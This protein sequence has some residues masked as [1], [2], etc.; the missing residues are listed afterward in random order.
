MSLAR[1]APTLAAGLQELATPAPLFTLPNAS[2]INVTAQ[3]AGGVGEEPSIAP[4]AFKYSLVFFDSSCRLSLAGGS[5]EKG[6]LPVM[7]KI[8]RALLSVSDKTGLV[9]SRPNAGGG[10]VELISTGGT[11]KALREAGLTVRTSASTPASRKC[12][13]AG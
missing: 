6:R 8:R 5:E 10:G 4:Q 2:P 3:D 12:S 1:L 13:M 11:A 9:A 7:E